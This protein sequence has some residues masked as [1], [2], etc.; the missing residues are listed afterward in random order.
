MSCQ[1]FT[2][3][4]KSANVVLERVVNELKLKHLRLVDMGV[5]TFLST[6]ESKMKLS[7]YEIVVKSLRKDQRKVITALGLP[8]IGTD[9]KKSKAVV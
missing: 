1:Y 7:E 4:R 6:K 9:I 2:R 5:S 3:Y 8:K